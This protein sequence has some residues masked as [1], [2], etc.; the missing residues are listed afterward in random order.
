MVL[1]AVAA[2][3]AEAA[4]TVDNVASAGRHVSQIPMLGKRCQASCRSCARRLRSSSGPRR[5]RR[6]PNRA[7]WRQA[8]RWHQEHGSSGNDDRDRQVCAASQRSE[9]RAA[10]L[11]QL[12]RQCHG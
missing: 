1:T 12:I 3:G 11:R 4:V 6:N 2:S 8:L 5:A 10:S 9:T 7:A